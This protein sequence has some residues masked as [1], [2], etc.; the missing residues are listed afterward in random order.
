MK[1]DDM[2]NVVK[3]LEFD[4]EKTICD[5]ERIKVFIFRPS[6]LSKRFKDYD[7]TKNFQIWLRED[8]RRF[9]PNHLRIMI[10][11]NLRTRCRPDLKR[12][13]LTIFDNIFYGE[14]PDIELERI[15]N[16]R[17]EHYLNSIKVIAYLHQVFIAEQLYC[18]NKESKY[19]PPTLFYQGWVRQMIDS[20]KEIDNMCMSICNRQ[21]PQAKYTNKEN[22]KHKKFKENCKPLWY[23]DVT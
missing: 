4:Y 22:R 1:F 2:F 9:R 12:I 6:T 13:M 15:K 16:E 14:D 5:D 8:E 10:D 17:F 20:P 23:L 7:V 11:L 19:D 18:Y 3:K 21:P